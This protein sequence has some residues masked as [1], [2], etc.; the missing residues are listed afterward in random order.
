MQNKILLHILATTAL[1]MSSSLADTI[2]LKSGKVFEG[3]VLEENATDYILE[4]QITATIKDRKTVKKTDVESIVAEA[5]DLKPYESI[6][7]TLP[8]P[9]QLSEGD[10]QELIE[11]VRS[12]VKKYPKSEY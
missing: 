1:G 4:I 3:R 11:P 8:T 6:K 10:Y 7:D 5:P 12:F 2:T 9:D